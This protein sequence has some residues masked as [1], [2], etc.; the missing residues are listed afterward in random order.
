MVTHIEASNDGNQILMYNE[1]DTKE[2]YVYYIDD[3]RLEFSD[4]TVFEGNHYDG[5]AFMEEKGY[6]LD[7]YDQTAYLTMDSWLQKMEKHFIRKICRVCLLLY[8]TER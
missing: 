4:L 6:L 3:K 5:L 8:Q 1:P 2:R 7:A